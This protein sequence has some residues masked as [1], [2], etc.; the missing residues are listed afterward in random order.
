MAR[1]QK[2]AALRT[3]RGRVIRVIVV[4][5]VLA[6]LI[7]CGYVVMMSNSPATSMDITV[8]T[9][10]VTT[11]TGQGPTFP[12]EIF[13]KVIMDQGLVD[14]TQQQLDGLQRNVWGGGIIASPVYLYQFSFATYGVPTEVYYGNL[15]GTVWTVT[16]WGL[17]SSVQGGMEPRCTGTTL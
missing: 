5:E 13:H 8:W 4:L 1:Q 11:Q 10:N 2:N 12:K 6:T 17:P 15:N 16:T 9:Q 7:L 3:C 14:D